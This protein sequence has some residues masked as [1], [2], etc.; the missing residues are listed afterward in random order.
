MG[1]VAVEEGQE[2]AEE[3]RGGGGGR[4]GYG[5]GEDEVGVV[6]VAVQEL[7]VYV[8]LHGAGE[9]IHRVFPV[10]VEMHAVG[11]VDA[12]LA[13]L[14]HMHHRVPIVDLQPAALQPIGTLPLLKPHM[15][16]LSFGTHLS[17]VPL[18]L[19]RRLHRVQVCIALLPTIFPLRLEFVSVV[20]QGLPVDGGG[21][22][23]GVGGGAGGTQGDEGEQA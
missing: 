5:Q 14:C 2:V 11:L 6:G 22:G 17:M 4:E 23:G 7:V 15:N 21:Q 12:P 10:I 3:G 16:L 20:R 19:H 18:Q 13:M 1:G 9:A 8:E